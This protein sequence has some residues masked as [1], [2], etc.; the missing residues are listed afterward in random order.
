[1]HPFDTHNSTLYLVYILASN[2]PH[3]RYILAPLIQGRSEAQFFTM[4]TI[5]CSLPMVRSRGS[6]FTA[7]MGL[8]TLHANGKGLANTSLCTGCAILDWKDLGT[9]AW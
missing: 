3:F 8:K 2:L 1:M 9:T 6:R 5:P 7:P 4:A